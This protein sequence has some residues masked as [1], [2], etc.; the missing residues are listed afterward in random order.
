MKKIFA[1]V[2][3]MC[4]AFADAQNVTSLPVMDT[5][6]TGDQVLCLPVSGTTLKRLPLSKIKN[7]VKVLPSGDAGEVQ[8]SAVTSFAS[9]A[10]FTRN[11]ANGNTIIM[12]TETEDTVLLSF[13][14][15]YEDFF[16]AG[17]A[18]SSA[19][20]DDNVFVIDAVVDYESFG[21]PGRGKYGKV[22]FF[23][24]TTGAVSQFFVD[25]V[26]IYMV[27]DGA[28]NIQ[29]TN[30]LSLYSP[31]SIIV[32]SNNILQVC[33][34]FATVVQ[35]GTAPSYNNYNSGVGLFTIPG[36][37]TN[38]GEYFKL[39]KDSQTV[40]RAMF[41]AGNKPRFVMLA[42][43]TVRNSSARLNL[44]ANNIGMGAIEDSLSITF[45]LHPDDGGVEVIADSFGVETG[46]YFLPTDSALPG[47]VM[48]AGADLKA[49]WED[50]PFGIAKWEVPY[51]TGGS[52]TSSPGLLYID[53]T[54]FG[55]KLRAFIASSSGDV[56][57]ADSTYKDKNN[58]FITIAGND[59]IS[60]IR[61]QFGTFLYMTDSSNLA[62]VRANKG[63]IGIGTTDETEDYNEGISLLRL[64]TRDSTGKV[65]IRTDTTEFLGIT[66]GDTLAVSFSNTMA[67]IVSPDNS[68]QLKGKDS[69]YLASPTVF[70]SIDSVTAYALVCGR[71]TT[72][73]CTDCT[74]VDNSTGGC[75]VTYTGSL[76]KRHW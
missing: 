42:Q 14:G 43:D 65:Q 32:Y 50:S 56:D 39:Q 63:Y 30:M 60:Q 58:S 20:E 59:T 51:G 22:I 10:G 36:Y 52:L 44:E 33:D 3:I 45:A 31:D 28:V 4:I 67:N 16:G 40:T 13:V 55:R 15:Q 46:R 61:L 2:L 71:G 8:Y 23:T 11:A 26:G 24:D 17:E 49:Y 70:V 37:G 19:S 29:G 41:V 47:Q 69:I 18:V 57:Y 48:V 25:S 5:C 74:P 68:L 72:L 54:L 9:D 64:E 6:Q 7:I 76:W 62:Y 34:T 12:T 21:I 35:Y 53:T 27:S 75:L 73:Y 38:F 66:S 1:A